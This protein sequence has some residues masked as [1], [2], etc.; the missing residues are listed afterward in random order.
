M[1]F[2]DTPDHVKKAIYT[3]KGDTQI[4][5]GHGG[6]TMALAP[7]IERAAVTTLTAGMMGFMM[8]ISES[9]AKKLVMREYGT[10]HPLAMQIVLLHHS[11][12]MQDSLASKTSKLGDV[13]RFSP[14]GPELIGFLD[15]LIQA[16][17]LLDGGTATGHAAEL[18][19]LSA[20]VVMAR[21]HGCT[22]VTAYSALRAQFLTYSAALHAWCG[23]CSSGAEP[24]VTDHF[25]VADRLWKRAD[26]MALLSTATDPAWAGI[27]RKKEPS[28]K[29]DKVPPAHGDGVVKVRGTPRYPR[30][31]TA[32]PC[33]FYLR[34]GDCKWGENCHRYCYLTRDLP[35]YKP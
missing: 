17:T 32:N 1:N 26:A 15:G 33:K 31:L 3:G 12:P 22:V 27:S 5:I 14:S 13:E 29:K 19:A 34:G 25:E 18:Q 2:R 16:A 7:G 10:V 35:R 28:P 23:P 20:R 30:H 21:N 11:L 8:P 9:V 24:K 6:A 4:K